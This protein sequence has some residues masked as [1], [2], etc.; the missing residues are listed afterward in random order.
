MK[1]A[2]QLW[3]VGLGLALLGTG[4]GDRPPTSPPLSQAEPADSAT[5]PERV[6]QVAKTDDTITPDSPEGNLPNELNPSEEVLQRLP[7][8]NAGRANPF[9]AILPGPIQVRPRTPS[10]VEAGTTSPPVPPTILSPA[11]PSASAPVQANPLPSVP[12]VPS[13]PTA[14]PA[15]V[16]ALPPS[17]PPAPPPSLASQIRISGIVQIGDQ[18]NVLVEVPNGGGSRPVRVGEDIVSGRVRLARV[19]VG[20]NQEPQVVLVEGG[21]ETVKTVDSGM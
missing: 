2:Y 18:L 14:P 7:Q 6:T 10:P 21:V 11:A 16:A 17:P 12:P 20:A 5:P 4:C 13:T 9:G 1:R 8:A 15:P 3:L 19:N